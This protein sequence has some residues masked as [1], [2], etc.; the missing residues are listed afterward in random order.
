M[1]KWDD[2]YDKIL[3]E[4]LA[5]RTTSKSTNYKGSPT[6]QINLSDGY[7]HVKAAANNKTV[8]P[9]SVS[10]K[11][12]DRMTTK[13]DNKKKKKWYE[14]G[15]FEDGWDVGDLTKTILGIDEDSA[16]LK[17]LT[18][19]SLKR[20][21]Y[22]SLYG[23]ESYKAMNGQKNKKDAYEKLLESDEYQFTP[24]SKVASGVSGAFEL[25]GQMFRQFTNPRT[26]A[27]TGS[28]VGAAIIAGNAGPQ[29]LVPEEI[30]SVPTVAAAAFAS[31]SA[32]SN[33]EIEAGHAYN[34][35]LEAGIKEET[36]RKIA[37]GVGGVNAALEAAQ[38]D[39]LLDAYK[40]TKASGATKSVAKRI[41]DE[42][43]DRGVD[44][45]KETGQEVL[46]EGVTIAGVQAASKLDKGEYAY[47]AADIG[48]R[49]LD[50][51][52]SSALSFGMMNVPAAAKN[53]FSTI[54]DQKMANAK[55]DK[56]VEAP[57]VE[58]APVVEQK[59]VVE[60]SPV[61][62][63]SQAEV[64][65]NAET[66]AEPTNDNWRD[67]AQT[68][69]EPEFDGE[70]WTREYIDHNNSVRKS[71]T[72]SAA[73]E[74][75]RDVESGMSSEQLA[76]KSQDALQEYEQLQAKKDSVTSYTE[77][78]KLTLTALYN[79]YT[80]YDSVAKN[81]SYVNEL[82]KSLDTA[83]VREDVAEN[84]TTTPTVSE[85]ENVSPVNA[86][87]QQETQL[88]E[89]NS[90]ELPEAQSEYQE[91]VEER[92]AIK[93]TLESLT[94]VSDFGDSFNELS[95]RYDEVN[96]KI[97]AFENAMTDGNGS[98]GEI[99]PASEAA[100]PEEAKAVVMKMVN[101]DIGEIAE[102]KVFTADGFTVQRRMSSDEKHWTYTVIS[103]D[104]T[105]RRGMT[106]VDA[107]EFWDDVQNSIS[108]LIDGTEV[109][110][111]IPAKAPVR[112]VSTDNGDY[113]ESDSSGFEEKKTETKRARILTDMPHKSKT[114]KQTK[115]TDSLNV[116]KE[117]KNGVK[118]IV[119]KI[120][121]LIIDNGFVFE[122]LSKKTKNRELEAKWDGLRR[123]RSAA[124][125]LIGNGADGVKSLKSMMDT[126][127]K[128]GLTQD[129]YNYLGH[130]RNI[131]GMT[132]DTR[133]NTYNRGVWGDVSAAESQFE[134][135]RLERLHPEFKSWAEDVYAYNNH[136]RDMMVKGG[137]ISQKTADLLAEMYPHYVPIHRV[138]FDE[139]IDYEDTNHVGVTSPLKSATGGNQDIEPL[140]NTMAERT[141]AVHRAV[142]MN[143]FGLELYNTL[144]PGRLNSNNAIA[145]MPSNAGAPF[146]DID[147]D[148]SIEGFDPREELLQ[149]GKPGS[150]PT[151]SVFMNGERH[152][153]DINSEMYTAMKPTSDFLSMSIPF[154][155]GFNNLRRNLITAYNPWFAL[156]N[157][158]K[159][160]QEVLINS[161]HPLKTYGN[162][163]VRV[164]SEVINNGKLYQEYCAN[165]GKQN[166]YFDTQD[167]SFDPKKGVLDYIENTIGLK[168]I[169]A[170]NNYIEMMPRF[171]EYI[172]SRESGRS[173]E[174]SMLDAARVTTNFGA[175]GKFT[176]LLD[177]NGWTFLNSSF[178]GATQQIRNVVEAKQNGIKGFAGL[179]A[180][181]MLAGLPAV[182]L[183]NALWEDDEEYQALPD[184]ITNN[185][186]I[187]FKY[188]DGQFVRIPKG[189]TA[190]VIQ[191]AI[192]Q[193][194][195]KSTGDDEADWSAFGDLIL[196][197]LAPNNP[198]K[199][200]ILAP[201]FQVAANESW[202]G[203]DIV[204]YRLKDLPAS[205]Q[206]DEKTDDLS[207]W[208]GE[209]LDY[210][211]K[212]I[213]Y[214]LD[215]YS[216]VLG[217]T[218][219]PYL[220][221]KAESPID[222][223]IL[224]ALAPFRDRFTTDSVLNNRVTGD[225]YETLEAA[226]AKAESDE[227][228]PE[229]KLVSSYLIYHNAEISKLMQQQRDIQTS[230]LP[231]SEKYKQNREL[232]EQINE[233]QKKALEGLEN[234][235]LNGIYGEV[236]DK[237]FNFGYDSENKQDRWFEIKPKKAD[238]DDNWYYQQEQA[239]TKDLGISYK[240]YWNNKQMYDDF[241]YVASG[242]DKESTSDD[243]IET[244][245]SVFGY[246]RFADYASVLKT[247][248]ADKDKNGESIDG[249][250]FPKVQEY[251]NSLDIPEIE[252]K[253]LMKMQYPNYKK[254]NYEIVEYLD[255]KDGISPT[256]V[257]KI[258]EELGYMIDSN[259]Y[260]TW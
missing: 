132:L 156:N 41:L 252:K 60:K 71:V 63:Q 140:F 173:I 191:Y 20:G 110:R 55:N 123:V 48:N 214:L 133:F 152:T 94:A 104:G 171:A 95:K 28:A 24:G 250:R 139:S 198:F 175:G 145:P 199:D 236:G 88:T 150:L 142:A 8:A 242:F 31:G 78:E 68:L 170:L 1:A 82:K 51:A 192:E 50:T 83:P 237:R 92:R 97:N 259:G 245:R 141:M 205:E 130:Y 90:T 167:S 117:T 253:I 233:M 70:E 162:M 69:R 226:E 179:A 109:E 44:V 136:L 183:N 43:V 178:Q 9:T 188:G 114:Q 244:A 126:V 235:S 189:R 190:A 138:G 3:S 108:H 64:K 177:R 26:L 207:V 128:A 251:V 25:G 75:I 116:D 211:P 106:E 227:A 149:S 168:Q 124:Q 215:Q 118:S 76:Q 79:Q 239:V 176:K 103:P 200:H 223:P 221:P 195:K 15:L 228:T 147:V 131:D 222:N 37:I 38:V 81:P 255:K 100:N 122:K 4:T 217:D 84:A 219:L 11:V 202:Y 159:D 164:H 224:K 160:A 185:Y 73:R 42:L 27:V 181:Y 98:T 240:E 249:T 148:Y 220:T 243:M 101:D 74:V 119:N 61:V 260:V 16:S 232:K 206:F 144:Y 7:I 137:L 29:A 57:F 52:Q 194:M 89:D 10:S 225:F 6:R 174:V 180:R 257:I 45:A 120:E 203:E 56:V 5:K 86:T 34:E 258:L 80:L 155:S 234:F 197:N 172:A 18:V 163:L 184:Y 21:Y 248:K 13:N 62:E 112:V 93:D 12:T 67:V 58:K 87:Q 54:R 99:S 91:L 151:F 111:S 208:L 22:N 210:S 135:D 85:T 209:K 49:L 161:Q 19:N 143:N 39:E 32:A 53:T 35:M 40:I 218:I 121:E 129:F 166:T 204:P 231:D 72:E 105:F 157:A 125:H 66:T 23:E 127:E 153:F 115:K 193:V 107:T 146:A 169:L 17:D 96:E 59:P 154:V 113:L 14:D 256:K 201:A 212:K 238:G 102:E 196:E 246:E 182:L 165:G 247:L 77:A 254:H 158:V 46:Q 33:Y 241:Y 186:Y 230:D 2:E 65:P 213:N 229:D 47:S 30:I 134:V 216:G 187:P 36:A